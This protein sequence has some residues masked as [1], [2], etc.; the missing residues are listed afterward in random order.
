[1][2]DASHIELTKEPDAAPLCPLDNHEWKD[3]YYGTRCARCD[4]F[5]PSGSA[6]WEYDPEEEERTA[7]EEYYATH[8]TCEDCFGEYGDGWSNCTCDETTE[9]EDADL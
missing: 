1:M 9:D 5:Y 4:L 7:R 6:P 8:G 3:D 2:D